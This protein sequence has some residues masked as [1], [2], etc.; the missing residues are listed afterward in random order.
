MGRAYQDNEGRVVIEDEAGCG[1]LPRE[2]TTR[3]P[4]P[5]TPPELTYMKYQETLK[6][7]LGIIARFLENGQIPDEE[8][9]T[10]KPQPPFYIV[11]DRQ[12]SADES[13]W[14]GL[15]MLLLAFGCLAIA[16]AFIAA[17]R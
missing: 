5:P 3:E 10:R 2:R 16:G 12:R 9:T 15:K 6:D 11:T 13:Q 1:W 14:T 7:D 4:Q 17:L 8:R